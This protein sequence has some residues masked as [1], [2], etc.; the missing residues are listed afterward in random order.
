M[1]EVSAPYLYTYESGTLKEF[2]E[3]I[4]IGKET[5]S[6]TFYLIHTVKGQKFLV[7][8]ARDNKVF[9]IDI[10]QT[11]TGWQIIEPLSEWVKEIENEL[12]Y[13]VNRNY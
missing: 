13:I 12:I 2:K 9:V 7:A 5:A 6:L 3:N 1:N 4:Y 10:L 8:G 11:S